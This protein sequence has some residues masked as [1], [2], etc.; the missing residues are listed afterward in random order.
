MNQTVIP[1]GVMIDEEGAQPK[2]PS[3]GGG[4]GYEY[5]LEQHTVMS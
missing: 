2:K 5:F 4:V 3:M 1:K